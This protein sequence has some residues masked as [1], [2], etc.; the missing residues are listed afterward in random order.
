MDT[1]IRGVLILISAILA[2]CSVGGSSTGSSE[3]L[4]FEVHKARDLIRPFYPD[5]AEYRVEMSQDNPEWYGWFSDDTIYLTDL[6]VM[7]FRDNELKA[8][9][10]VHEYIHA[11]Q[12][13]TIY[14][15]DWRDIAEA[16]AYE[17]EQRCEM[18]L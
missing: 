14:G 18:R 8:C 2:S 15:T 10:I 12:P 17:E 1:L 3:N 4:P 9:T 6:W 11:I 5:A 16:E 7:A 13:N